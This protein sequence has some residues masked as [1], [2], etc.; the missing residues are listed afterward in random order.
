MATWSRVLTTSDLE[1]ITNTDFSSADLT[2]DGDRTHSLSNQTLTIVG[3][4]TS[5]RF[6]LDGVEVT[7]V[8]SDDFDAAINLSPSANPSV[9][10]TSFLNRQEGSTTFGFRL[11]A[12]P[13]TVS[14]GNQLC[15]YNRPDD[16][17]VGDMKIASIEELPDISNLDSDLPR[18]ILSAASDGDFY[19]IANDTEGEKHVRVDF[20]DLIGALVLDLV[21]A[22]VEAGIGNTA[23]Y[24]NDTTGVIGDFNGDGSVSTADLLEFLTL[25]GAPP[26]YPS[27]TTRTVYLEL[28][29]LTS[30]LDASGTGASD[31]SAIIESGN[32]RKLGISSDTDATVV[33]ATGTLDVVVDSGNRTITFSNPAAGNYSMSGAPNKVIRIREIDSSQPAFTAVTAVAGERLFVFMKV[34]AFGDGGTQVGNDFYVNVSDKTT[35][36]PG[37]QGVFLDE[38]LFT[39]GGNGS[40]SLSNN[41]TLGTEISNGL[42]NTAISSLEVSFYAASLM[43][44]ASFFQIQDVQIKVEES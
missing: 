2:L 7:V 21:N 39:I 31:Y 42:A 12:E 27:Y 35:T 37:T 43:G 16:T 34:R 18:A 29:P 20:N 32:L 9:G 41:G 33:S 4:G 1:N 36:E 3:G 14:A 17:V 23:T 24:T 22:N 44:S 13:T 11:P 38:S 26:T 40:G 30:V 8:D 15:L 5:S 19:F 28:G 10:G 6:V 25:F